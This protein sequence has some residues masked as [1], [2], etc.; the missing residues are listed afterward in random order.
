MGPRKLNG[1]QSK[2]KRFCLRRWGGRRVSFKA[3]TNTNLSRES[4]HEGV[5]LECG[6]GE[7]RN[8]EDSASGT[9]SKQPDF[10]S[11]VAARRKVWT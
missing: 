9:K 1:C 5:A 8:T 2:I 6:S 3:Q 7:D 11:Q 4:K 10:T